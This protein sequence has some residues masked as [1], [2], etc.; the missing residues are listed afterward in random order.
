M[1]CIGGS[2]ALQLLESCVE[3]K[4]VTGNFTKKGI[5]IPKDYFIEKKN[6]N[7]IVYKKYLIISNEQL[8]YPIYISR[9]SD[10]DYKAS[11]MQCTHLGAE[12]QAF[13]EILQ[14]P[15]HGS[16]FN[17]KGEVLNGPATRNLRS[18]PV[19]IESDSLNISLS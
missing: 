8:K 5:S 18:F 2:V 11:L 13:G 19:T 1:A 17:N 6:G 10:K 16:E 3:S 12:L 15:A 7:D 9:I 14:C 4:M